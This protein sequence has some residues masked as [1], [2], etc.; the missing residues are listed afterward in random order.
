M[1][2][3]LDKAD[4][5]GLSEPELVNRLKAILAVNQE[6]ETIKTRWFLT[7]LCSV[8]TISALISER[9]CKFPHFLEITTDRPTEC[10]T[11]KHDEVS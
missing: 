8:Q 6:E 3:D 9:N 10:P 5:A 2:A 4:M 11:Y 1:K 7:Q